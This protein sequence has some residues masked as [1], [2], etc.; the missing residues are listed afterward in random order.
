MS[1]ETR[2]FE[3]KMSDEGNMETPTIRLTEEGGLAVKMLAGEALVKGE[4]VSVKAG[5][6][7]TVEKTTASTYGTIGFVYDDAAADADVWVV[8][9]GVGYALLKDTVAADAGDYVVITDVDGRVDADA[10]SATGE[11]LGRCIKDHIAGVDV[12]AL[13]VIRPSWVQAP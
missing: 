9:S 6:D 3:V 5:A 13:M 1:Q 2:I 8:I 4:A 10:S 12:L 7:N 11:N